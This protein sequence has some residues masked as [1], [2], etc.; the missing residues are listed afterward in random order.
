MKFPLHIPQTAPFDVVGYGTN[1]VDHLIEVARYPEFNTKVNLLSHTV[2]A[3]GE[4]ATTLVGLQRL[5]LRTAYVGRIGDDTAGELGLESLVAEGVDSAG[6]ERV[7]GART[8]S[9]FIIIERQTGERTIIW[10]RE[11]KLAYTAGEAPVEAAKRCRILHMTAHDTAACIRMA[12]AAREAGA[13]VSVD[14]DNVVDGLDDLLPLVDVLITSSDLPSNLIGTRD[15]G[16]ALERIHERY[17]C[18][19][20]GSTIGSEGSVLFSNGA[21]V[22]TPSFPVP[23]GCRDTTGAGD[24]FRTGLLYGMLAG[25][26]TATTA[27]IANATAALNCRRIGARAGLPTLNEINRLLDDGSKA[28]H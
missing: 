11:K 14:L 22:F 17:G 2:A 4:I 28:C 18:K 21:L 6:C 25:E 16:A 27:R 7:A 12:A 10:D 1:A 5:G 3:G 20:V 26:D 23:G 8:Q 13:I 9:A 19:V 15:R 24:A